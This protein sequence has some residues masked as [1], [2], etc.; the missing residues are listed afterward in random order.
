MTW[1]RTGVAHTGLVAINGKLSMRSS[2]DSVAL[3]AAS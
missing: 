3:T 2:W 1:C